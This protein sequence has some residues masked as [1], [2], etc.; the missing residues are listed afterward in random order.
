MVEDSLGR[1]ADGEEK[2]EVG[3]LRRG[4]VQRCVTRER[5]KGVRSRDPIAGSQT[6]SGSFVLSLGVE[7][8]V[9]YFK[10]ERDSCCRILFEAGCGFVDRSGRSI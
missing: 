3:E 8:G 2:A 4:E 9:T 10:D 6:L 5:A 1:W 7:R